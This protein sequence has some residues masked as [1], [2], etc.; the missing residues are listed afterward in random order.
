[1]AMH[2][3]SLI[4]GALLAT[5]TA[6]AEPTIFHTSR[7][8]DATTVSLSL[9]SNQFSTHVGYD[10]DVTI[11]L[12]ELDG[13]GV[14]AYRDPWQSPGSRALRHAGKCVWP[15]HMLPFGPSRRTFAA[16]AFRMTPSGTWR[17]SCR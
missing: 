2:A 5:T 10:F 8:P 14:L 17:V 3:H 6:A 9:L 15:A 1:M 13:S 11:G 7:F 16:M 4:V 12:A